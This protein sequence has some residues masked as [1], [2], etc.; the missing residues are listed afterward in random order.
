MA[1]RAVHRLRAA[2]DPGSSVAGAV[3]RSAVR[4]GLDDPTYREPGTIVADQQY[5]QQVARDDLS[6]SGE[7]A[8]AEWFELRQR[9]GLDDHR[10]NLG[11]QDEA[12][13]DANEVADVGANQARDG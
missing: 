13:D 2:G 5:A 6:R 9:N 12:E 1:Y 4:L 3:F 8:P 7:E 10:P 11:R